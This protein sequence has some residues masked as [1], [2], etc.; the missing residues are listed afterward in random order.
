MSLNIIG[1]AAFVVF[2]AVINLR[3]KRLA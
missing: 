2:L 3:F 1:I